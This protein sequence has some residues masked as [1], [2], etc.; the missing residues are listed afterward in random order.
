MTRLLVVL[1]FLTIASPAVAQSLVGGS[2]T[3]TFFGCDEDRSCHRITYS[4]APNPE[5]PENQTGTVQMRSWFFTP[6]AMV[7]VTPFP[8]NYS[9]TEVYG[10]TQFKYYSE[11]YIDP[12]HAEGLEWRPD[13]VRAILAYGPLGLDFHDHYD[14][15]TSATLSL[16]VTP[17]PASLLLLAT[18]LGGVLAG[19][20]RRRRTT[21]SPVS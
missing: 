13:V 1:A 4:L 2:W 3:R 20:R 9:M 12:F 14:L 11:L 19:A 15:E 16:V 6:G 8:F 17:E 10:D 7:Y 5:F 18:G 21:S